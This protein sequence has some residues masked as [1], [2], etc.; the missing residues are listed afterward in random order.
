MDGVSFECM[1]M[2]SSGTEAVAKLAFNWARQGQS[3]TMALMVFTT[4]T[5]DK[6]TV[7][8]EF[9]TLAN[10]KHI[11][12]CIVASRRAEGRMERR[13]YEFVPRTY[14]HHRHGQWSDGGSGNPFLEPKWYL[15]CSIFASNPLSNGVRM[16][17]RIDEASH[18]SYKA[19][20]V[21]V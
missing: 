14:A 12:V 6:F 18:H 17:S 1:E 8:K 3:A 19:R 15:P 7:S 20:Q 16:A 11:S 5:P 13:R 21:E 9:H 4:K 2:I 10:Q